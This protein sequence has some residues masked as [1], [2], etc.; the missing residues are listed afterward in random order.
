M[1]QKP[2]DAV[3]V[4]AGPNGLTAAVELARAGL[5]VLVLEAEEQIGGGTRSLELT[6]P[7]FVHDVCSA[8][9]P[10]G[11]LSPAFRTLE[12]EK[13][14]VQWDEPELA[15]A[16]PFDDG[17]AAVVA[18]SLEE[19]ARGLGVDAARYTELLRPLVD[20]AE[21]FFPAIL[22]PIRVPAQP[23]FMARF[24]LAALRSCE[25]LT[26]SLFR[27]DRTRA[28]FAGCASHAFVPPDFPGTASFG[29]VLLSS[30]HVVSWPCARGGSQKISDALAARLTALGGEIRTAHRVRSLRDVPSSRAVLFDLTPRQIVEIAGSE[31]PPAYL[32]R[33]G[34]FRYGP[35]VFKIDWALAGPIPWTAEP[36]RRAGTVHVGGA[37]EE[38]A[39]NETLS[40]KGAHP[41]R[42]LVLVAQQSL[43]DPTRAPGGKQ[44]GWAYC[45]VPHGSDVD[46]T[47]VI[48]RQIE[49]FAPGFRDLILARH[50]FT[51]LQIERHN[52]NMVGGD[53]GGGANT[54][55]QFL[56]RPVARWD[57]YRTP[58]ERLYLCSSSTPPGGGV[59]GMC[60]WHAARSALARTFGIKSRAEV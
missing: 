19:T 30:A 44:T 10:V 36:C 29:L 53:V 45:H 13:W 26:R 20:H 9:H 35:G 8:I 15:L 60:G 33:L 41:E 57:P 21:T 54:L 52:A 59:H 39:R 16:H 50:S 34:R 38:I 18:R 2:Y 37:Y 40:W 11:A 43:F 3:V 27:E 48:E 1:N 58:N 6:L 24:G 22:R 12:L 31:L 23:F 17:S 7:G 55:D 51:P 4:G 42:P 14:G 32:R 5:S 28:L 47:D 49:R 25:A 46:M 56:A